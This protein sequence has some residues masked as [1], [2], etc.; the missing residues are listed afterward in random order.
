MNS[1]RVEPI[2][3]NKVI[4]V[5]V[6]GDKQAFTPNLVEAEIGDVLQFQFAAGNHSVT[7]STEGNPCQP[8]LDGAGASTSIHSGFMSFDS[9][10]ADVPTFNVPIRDSSPMFFYSAHD[11]QCQQGIVMAVNA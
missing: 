1:Q 4:P 10:N 7:Q 3:V 5:I 9:K 11:R 2:S 6:G 8:I